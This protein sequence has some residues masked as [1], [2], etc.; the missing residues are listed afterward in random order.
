MLDNMKGVL[1]DLDGTLVDSMWMWKSI[2]I[3]YLGQFHISLPEDLQEAIEGKSFSETALYFKERF[4]IPQS[5]EEIK[6]EWNRMAWEKYEREVSIKPGALE[7]LKDLK[8]RGIKMAIA[9]SNSR[10]IAEMVT[11]VH[12]IRDLFGTIVTGCEVAFGKPYPDVFLKA[13]GELK[14]EPEHCLVFEDI[15][16]GILAGKKAGMKVCAVED[17]YSRNLSEKKR[18]MADYYIK[19]YDDIRNETYEVLT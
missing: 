14:V 6:E 8:A 7:F 10:A 16:N 17:D 11:E 12:G 13:A 2:D 1:F 4:S 5:L 18:K 19:T 9:T 3:E 15:P